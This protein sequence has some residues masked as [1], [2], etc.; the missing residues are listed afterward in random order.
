MN[1]ID[2]ALALLANTA[3]AFNFIAGKSGLEHFSPLLF[4]ALR[5]SLLLVLLLPFLRWIPGQ[6]KGVLGVG[7]VL[8]IFHFGLIFAGLAAA[9]DV[10]SIAIAA[11]L[12]VPFSAILAVLFLRET[13]GWR[14]IV[15]IACA[16]CGVMVIGFDPIVFNHPDALFFTISAALVMAIATIMMRRL[17]GV[18]VFTLQAWIALIAT[19]S[20]MLLSLLLEQN[21]LAVLR[22][23]TWLDYAMPAYSAIGAS[24]VGHGIVYYLLGRHPVSVTA[25]LMLLTPVLAVFFGV[26]IWGDTLTWKLMLGGAMTL[27]GVAV[28]TIRAPQQALAL[29][30][31]PAQP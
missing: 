22:S 18:S 17:Q 26:V 11:Q 7:V 12:Y 8:G 20:M 29:A 23:A 28:I 13:L 4:T 16:F 27:A 2:L 24:L 6:M 5:F 14:R 31:K 15:G 9:G 25:P 1:P 10:S 30:S 3:W 19:P 21:Q